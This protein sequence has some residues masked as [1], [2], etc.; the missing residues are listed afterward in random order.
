MSPMNTARRL[1]LT[2]RQCGATARLAPRSGAP[3]CPYAPWPAGVAQVYRE[4][5]SPLGLASG[6]R[7]PCGYSARVA[8]PESVSGPNSSD[9]NPPRCS[10]TGALV[11]RRIGRPMALSGESCFLRSSRDR[12]IPG[13]GRWRPGARPCRGRRPG[14]PAPSR[15]GPE[16]AL[17]SAHAWRPA[18]SYLA[19]S[20]GVLSAWLPL[21]REGPFHC[22]GRPLRGQIHNDTHAAGPKSMRKR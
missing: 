22:R 21:V 17:S 1:F 8:R 14:P 18:A 10:F 9:K 7:C 19:T 11:T 16:H 6:G 2:C 15:G 5:T 12:A 3:R 13:A 20:A 4:Q